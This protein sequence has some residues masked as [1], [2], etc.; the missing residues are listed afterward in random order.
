MS[1]VV[2]TNEPLFTEQ[3]AAERL[4]ISLEQLHHLLDQHVFNDGGSRPQECLFRATDLHLLSFWLR[5][6][7][8]PQELRIS[9]EI[10]T[11]YE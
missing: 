4:G 3:E 10:S 7:L 6:K 5:G 9:G 8:H 11:P 2:T 1:S